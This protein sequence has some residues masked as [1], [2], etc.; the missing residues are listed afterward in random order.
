MGKEVI[1]NSISEKN[2]GDLGLLKTMVEFSLR[3]G[4]TR[5]HIHLQSAGEGLNY[6]QLIEFIKDK[7][8]NEILE[9]EKYLLINR[10]KEIQSRLDAGV[11]SK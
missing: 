10:L 5:Y 2:V 3:Y 9:E 7:S 1:I 8:E 11:D 4:A 6:V